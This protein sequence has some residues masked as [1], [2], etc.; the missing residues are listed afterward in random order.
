[1][2]DRFGWRA[3]LVFFALVDYSEVSEFSFPISPFNVQ[4]ANLGAWGSAATE[5]YCFLN[6]PLFAFEDSFD[7]SVGCVAHPSC[8][9]QAVSEV[10]CFSSEEYALN[11]ASHVNV[12][13]C[14]HRSTIR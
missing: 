11:P 13:P 3:R 8:E 6:A 7:A 12:G 5:F 14:L 4:F 2:T 10:G 1:M 9:A